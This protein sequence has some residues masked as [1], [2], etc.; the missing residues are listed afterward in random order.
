VAGFRWALARDYALV[1]EMDA[2]FSH[3]PAH[4][5]TFLAAADGAD[6]V[7]GSRY[8]FGKVTVVNWPI[9]RL[10]LSYAANVY[11][12]AVTGLPVFDATGGFKCFRRAVLAALDLDDV[13]SNGYAFQIEMSFRAWRRGS[14]SP[15]SHRVRRSDGGAKQDVG[16]DRARGRLD[17]VAPPL[18][19]DHG[20]PVSTAG[21]MPSDV[22]F[23][24]LSGSGNDFVFFDGRGGAPAFPPDPA[25]IAALCSRGQGVG[26]DGVVY[27]DAPAPGVVEIVY[28]NSDGSR[29]ALCGNATLCTARLAVHLGLVAADEPF[30]IRTDSGEMPARVSPTGMPAFELAAVRD[31]TPD[32]PLIPAPSG[33]TPAAEARIGFAV[34]GVPHLVVR[35]GDVDAVD[36]GRRGAQLRQPAASR[37]EGANVNFV[38]PAPGGGAWRMRTFERGVEGETLACGTGAVATAALLRAWGE[39]G[40]DTRLITRSGRPV[41]VTEA[42]APGRGPVLTG[43]GR[44]VFEGWLRDWR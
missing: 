1:F 9:A 35:V 12:R 27:L 40:P 30:V 6:L 44:L 36:L 38:S 25:A 8:Q 23:Y 13:R 7:L 24:K 14:A 21:R 43:E 28:L 33:D 37:P 29:A 34:A 22:R 32:A 31:L 18:V 5:P 19:G 10:I 17:G 26:A 2:D 20:P 11:A 15:R 42:I 4:L 39:S 41:T 16:A 3:D